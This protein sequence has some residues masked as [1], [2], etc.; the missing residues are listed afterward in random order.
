MKPALP[1]TL[2]GLGSNSLMA[3]CLQG[4]G[5]RPPSCFSMRLTALTGPNITFAHGADL[6]AVLMRSI[7]RW[8]FWRIGD[9]FRNELQFQSELFQ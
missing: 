1:S 7:V 6:A 3:N 8:Q 4:T 5:N 9:D 2:Y